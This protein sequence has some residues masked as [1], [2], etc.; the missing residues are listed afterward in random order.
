[1]GTVAEATPEG[2]MMSKRFTG[3][4]ANF[5]ALYT[6]GG[7][8]RPEAYMKA[9]GV[10]DLIVARSNASRLML[11]NADV[12]AEIDKR[13]AAGIDAAKKRLKSEAI[14]TVEKLL[15]L[16]DRGNKE[17][18]VQ[19]SACKDILDRVGMKPKDE[20]DLTQ[21]G[22]LN[23]KLELPEDLDLDDII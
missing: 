4:Q 6:G 18:S 19:L 1:M 10:K 14:N 5:I 15:D 12:R 11:T 13:L 8:S 17:Y 2:G 3:Q 22:D 21:K 7:M 16:R 9:Y 20:I 23:I